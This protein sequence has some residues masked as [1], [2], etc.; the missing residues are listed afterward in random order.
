MIILILEI[1]LKE[2]SF[3]QYLSILD[4]LDSFREIS[5]LLT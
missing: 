2:F 3:Q 4:L 1:D 5:L